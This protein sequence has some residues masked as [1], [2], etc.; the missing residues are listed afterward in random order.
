MPSTFI[1]QNFRKISMKP[2]WNALQSLD[3]DEPPNEEETSTVMSRE[4]FKTKQNL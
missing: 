1:K 3:K 2:Q 4:Q